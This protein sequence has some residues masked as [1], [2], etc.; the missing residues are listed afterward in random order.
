MPDF[1]R[2]SGKFDPKIHSVQIV[3]S[4]SSL[5]LKGNLKMSGLEPRTS[6]LSM[7]SE[8]AYHLRYILVD[9]SANTHS[10]S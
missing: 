7:L 4:R 6:R 3:G 10:K 5:G 9:P 8:S 1:D 2:I